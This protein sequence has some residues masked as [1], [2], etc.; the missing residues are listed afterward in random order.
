[1]SNIDRLIIKQII[2]ETNIVDIIGKYIKVV[3]S[4]INYKACCPFHKEDH[5]SLHINEQKQFFYCFGCSVGGDVIKFLQ[6]Y[7]KVSFIEAVKILSPNS[8][9]FYD[10]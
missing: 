3:K 8:N 4:G 6:E 9:I 1:M 7:K 10:M 2:S 5:P